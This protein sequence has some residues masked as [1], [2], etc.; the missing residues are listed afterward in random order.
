MKKI[1]TFTK[2]YLV[3]TAIAFSLVMVLSGFS[4]DASAQP[5][6]E[7]APGQPGLGKAPGLEEYNNLCRYRDLDTDELVLYECDLYQSKGDQDTVTPQVKIISPEPGDT[8]N[9]ADLKDTNDN[10]VKELPITIV[11]SPQTDYV[12]D[13]TNVSN[14]GTQ[15]GFLPQEDGLGHLHAYIA[16]EI[17]VSLNEDDEYVVEFVGAENRADRVGGFCVFTNSIVK[18]DD[19]QVL[20]SNCD[21]FQSE[22]DIVFDSNYRIIVDA[23]DNSHG[24]RLKSHPRAVPP[25]DQVIIQFTNIEE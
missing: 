25:G 14:P 23:T 15:Y 8:I 13:F 17:A 5:G 11:L 7:K 1:Y 4:M 16:P 12:V 24:P 3:V 18:T 20:Q 21:L 22:E 10:G 2:T 19:Y 9:Y 6:K